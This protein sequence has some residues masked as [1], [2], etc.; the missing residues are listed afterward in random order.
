MSNSYRG[1]QILLAIL[2]LAWPLNKELLEL[3]YTNISAILY[4]FKWRT[5]GRIL[6]SIYIEAYTSYQL[7]TPPSKKNTHLLSH[8]LLFLIKF[9]IL[10]NPLVCIYKR[11]R[12]FSLRSPWHQRWM[13]DI[14]TTFSY[15]SPFALKGLSLSLAH[16]LPSS[17][18]SLPSHNTY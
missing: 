15:F 1:A 18:L 16:S 2:H 12:W 17:S 4:L 11:V 9:D 3:T 14:S 6:L 5:E 10:Q 13:N 8:G 7:Y